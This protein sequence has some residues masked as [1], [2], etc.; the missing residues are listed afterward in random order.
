MA[1]SALRLSPPFITVVVP[2]LNEEL[3]LGHCLESLIAQECAFTY[4]IIVVDNGSVDCTAEVAH[5]YG[6]RVVYEKRR[7]VGWARASGF[8]NARG[9]II[10]S[11]DADTVVPRDWLARFAQ[12]FQKHLEVVGVGG[13]FIYVDGPVGVRLLG[14]L[15]NYMTPLIVRMAPWFWSFSGFNFAVRREAYLASGG[16]RNDLMYGEDWDLGKRL[17]RLGRV[18]V[19]SGSW[20]KTSGK[21]SERDTLCIRRVINY[22]SLVFWG[23][24]YLRPIMRKSGLFG[25][26]DA[27]TRNHAAINRPSN[28]RN[29][30]KAK[31]L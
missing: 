20:V 10:A 5:R 24:T 31:L 29:K 26:D 21:A 4:E 2:A 6:A 15:A 8:A 9:T 23:H 22:F 28:T 3:A 11:T 19:D 25:E 18:V 14:R 17:C 27:D 1:S 16:F 7:G 30:G 12:I 13:R